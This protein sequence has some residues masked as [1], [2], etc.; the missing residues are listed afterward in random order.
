MYEERIYKDMEENETYQKTVYIANNML[1][2]VDFS[3]INFNEKE[4]DIDI[5]DS[6]MNLIY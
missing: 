2:N 4:K 6:S 1:N 3:K 5:D